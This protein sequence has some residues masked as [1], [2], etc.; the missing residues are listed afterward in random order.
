MPYD[1]VIKQ[2]A[3]EDAT[4]AYIYYQ[5]KQTGLGERFLNAL[6]EA[7][8]KLQYHPQHYSYI[9]EDPGKIFRDI[10]LYK[11]PYVIV[12]EIS[13]NEVIVYAVYCCYKNPIKKIKREA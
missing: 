1:L 2:E 3:V 11:F 10:K 13:T 7:Y 12:Y 5:E 8:E 9:D 6:K 4:E